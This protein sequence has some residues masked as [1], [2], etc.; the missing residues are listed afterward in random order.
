MSTKRLKKESKVKKRVKWL[1]KSDNGK[2]SRMS[3]TDKTRDL[4]ETN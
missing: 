1:K 4:W 2:G 3:E